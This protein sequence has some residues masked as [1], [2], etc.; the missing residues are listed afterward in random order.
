MLGCEARGLSPHE[1][2]EALRYPDTSVV[3][4]LSHL[5]MEGKR[6]L[7]ER[8]LPFVRRLRSEAGF[9][10]RV[11]LDEAHY[12]LADPET[13]RELD[14]EG[15]GLVLATYR[16]D[17]LASEVLAA[18]DLIIATRITDRSEVQAIQSQLAAA[19]ADL[20][21]QLA[22]LALDEAVVLPSGT[23]S[24]GIMQRLILAPR[25]TLHVRHR[26]K[27]LDVPVLA[28]H[29]FVF[30]HGGTPTGDRAATLAD[31]VSIVKS[32]PP[33]LL[34]GHLRRSDVSQWVRDVFGDQFLADQMVEIE[35]QSRAD[36]HLDARDAVVASILDRYAPDAAD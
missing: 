35:R 9:P 20:E 33:D 18:S 32:N 4:N 15:G 13:C 21:R 5:S 30:T 6:D 26:E 27:Y 3:V 23:D 28:R 34:R 29:A 7:V 16:V 36:R 12:F 2:W 11:F 22:N 1:V 8:L 14:L 25:L 17:Q 24:P 19:P 10:H 31:F